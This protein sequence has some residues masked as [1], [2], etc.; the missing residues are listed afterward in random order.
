MKALVSL[1]ALLCIAF[2][3][4]AQSTA[5]SHDPREI[6]LVTLSELS[7]RDGKLIFRTA[8]NGLTEAGSFAVRVRREAGTVPGV[9]AYRVAIERVK[10]DDGKMLLLDGVQIELDLA[11]DLRISG[12]CSLSFDNPISPKPAMSPAGGGAAG[13][14]IELQRSLRDSVIRAIGMEMDACASRLKAANS[15]TGS[16][17][18]AAALREKIADLQA[19]KARF[20]GMDPRDYPLPAAS[21]PDSGSVLE[22]ATGSGPVLPP[23][24][25]V[26]SATVD[27]PCSD[28]T[29]LAGTGAS[30][31]G[32]F[33]HLA[34]I[35]GGDYGLLQVG[36]S[37]TLT[38]YAV[39]RREYFS[40][41]GDFYVFVGQ[42]RE[43]G[44]R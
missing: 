43:A 27:S 17:G 30:R 14:D 35:G 22:Q 26:I 42:V 9:T 44:A 36:K 12:A 10:K 8:S 15:G 7:V 13:A 28:G 1:L 23:R 25:R 31:S 40:T 39:Y 32:P 19:E 20:E 33:Y 21:A 4:A 18:N 37:Y 6:G 5:L 34:G 16:S 38:V 3:A 41:I 24:Q 11:K 29:L 2:P